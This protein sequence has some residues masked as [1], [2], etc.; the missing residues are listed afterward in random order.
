MFKQFS[1]R[2][3]PQSGMSWVLDEDGRRSNKSMLGIRH[4]AVHPEAGMPTPAGL[5]S[6][7]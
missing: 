1:R 6:V 5:S 4:F 2:K 3:P 7:A